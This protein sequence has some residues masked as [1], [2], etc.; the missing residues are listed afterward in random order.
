MVQAFATP[1][2]MREKTI[3]ISPGFRRSSIGGT[4]PALRFRQRT[5]IKTPGILLPETQRD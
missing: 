3:A 1:F 4:M 2:K 5:S